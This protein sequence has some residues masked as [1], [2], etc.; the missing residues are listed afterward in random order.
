M[1]DEA[2]DDVDDDDIESDV[3]EMD[4]D[5]EV[6]HVTDLFRVRFIRYDE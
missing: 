1:G 6:E 3:D 2:D 5:D 4:D